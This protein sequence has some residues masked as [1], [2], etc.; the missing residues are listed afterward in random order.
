MSEGFRGK[1]NQAF[2]NGMAPYEE[3]LN[4]IRASIENGKEVSYIN[5]KKGKIPD[6]K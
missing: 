2:N 6:E 3:A 1:V 4:G 5:E